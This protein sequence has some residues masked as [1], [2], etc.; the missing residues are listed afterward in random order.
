MGAMPLPLFGNIQFYFYH[1]GKFFSFQQLIL[2]LFRHA[3]KDIFMIH[4]RVF[5]LLHCFHFRCVYFLFFLVSFILAAL[6]LL[7]F[8]IDLFL[9]SSYNS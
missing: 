9:R 8:A 7:Q 5:N 3:V 6:N 2:F 1:P 4:F